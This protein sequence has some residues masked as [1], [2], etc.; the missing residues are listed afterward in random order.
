MGLSD[1]YGVLIGTLKHYK[2]DDPNNFGNYMHGMLTVA[3]QGTQYTCAVDVDTKDGKTPIQWK[4]QP[5]RVGEWTDLLALPDGWHSLPS[6]PHSGAVDYIRDPRFKELLILP[7]LP[8]LVD[9]PKRFPFPPEEMFKR[10]AFHQRVI[11]APV[12]KSRGGGAVVAMRSPVAASLKIPTTPITVRSR[13]GRILQFTLPWQAG[14]SEQALADL[15]AVLASAHKLMVFGE[16]FTTGKG[17]H[18]IHQ[19]QGDPVNS[20]F[21]QENAIWQDGVTIAFRQDGTAAAFMNKFSTQA[22]ATNDAGRPL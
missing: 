18:N 14:S 5:L 4:V 13:L 15:E 22:D 7:E 2:R 20:K 8:K 17:V 1:G 3:A 10:F 19:N 11:S 12:L 9:G 16:P 21:A 6:T